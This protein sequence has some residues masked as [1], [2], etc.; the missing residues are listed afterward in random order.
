M[1]LTVLRYV[2]SY[3]TPLNSPMTSV[4]QSHDL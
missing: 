4:A 2:I 3:A 1:F